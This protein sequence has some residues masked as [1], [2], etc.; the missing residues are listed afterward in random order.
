MAV[1]FS[2]PAFLPMSARAMKLIPKR[3]LP[4]CGCT[5]FSLANAALRCECE[6]TLSWTRLEL[7]PGSVF[8]KSCNASSSFKSLM[9]S[10]SATNSSLRSFMFASYSPVFVAQFLSMSARNF[11]SSMTCSSVSDKS[12]AIWTA[13]TPSSPMSTVPVSICSERAAI[14]F[15]FAATRASVDLM[16]ASS[17]AVAAAR[18]LAISSFMVLR[19]PMISPVPGANSPPERNETI[20]SRSYSARS[21]LERIMAFRERA[22]PDWRKAAVPFSSAAIAPDSIPMFESDSAF[23]LANSEASLLRRAVADLMASLAA[24]RS[25]RFV[26]KFS[27]SC[28]CFSF[29]SCN[30]DAIVGTLASAPATLAFNS[31]PDVLQ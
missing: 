27:F 5:V 3:P 8:L 1:I 29:V 31:P 24:S 25:A 21:S 19:M 6:V 14:S 15:F 7:A 2:K 17:A 11:L 28:T 20:S 26:F 10:A 12:A 16:D 30:S 4:P 9:V 22:V 23:T 13:F 18:P